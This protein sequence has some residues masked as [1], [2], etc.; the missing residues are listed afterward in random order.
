M[1]VCKMGVNGRAEKGQIVKEAGVATMIL[2]NIEINLKQ[3]PVDV[4][5]HVLLATLID[6]DESIFLKSYMNSKR[7]PRAKIIFGG[8]IIGKSLAL[9][10]AQFST[11]GPSF[12]NLVIL[13][14][15]MIAPGVKHN[16]CLATK[17][18]LEWPCRRFLKSKLH[19]HVR[20]FHGS[21]NMAIGKYMES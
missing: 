7:R 21:L 3:D 16:C 1:V 8:T 14:S 10:I 4:D 5:V 13:K 2:V 12:A 19:Y 6:F 9:A 18:R 20:D 17:S 11:R 15:D